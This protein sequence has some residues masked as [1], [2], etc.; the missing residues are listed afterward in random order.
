VADEQ[1]RGKGR[2][3]RS[4][5]TRAGSALAFS[6]IYRFTEASQPG[7]P[8][9]LLAGLGGVAVCQALEN[10]YRLPVKIK[11]PNDVLI[12]RR[13]V[14]GVLAE[15]QWQGDQLIAAVLGIGVNVSR[16]ALPSPAELLFPATSVE[17]ENGSPVDRLRLLRAILEQLFFWQERL[18]R[19]EFLQTWWNHLAFRDELVRMTTSSEMIEGHISGLEPD[20]ALAL[21]DLSGQRHLLYQGEV[22]L[23]P[24]EL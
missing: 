15:T 5:V 10:E 20:G 6:L 8:V 17:E 13:K 22:S 19:A 12:R 7:I 1:I 23:R 9:G 18:S 21:I 4:W 14:A 24:G 11:W 2:A 16:E 3:G